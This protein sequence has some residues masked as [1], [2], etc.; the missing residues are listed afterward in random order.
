MTGT[1]SPARSRTERSLARIGRLDGQ[2]RSCLLVRPS[3][4]AEAE[5][6]DQARTAGPLAGWTLAVKDNMDVAGTVRTD[7]LGPPFRPP[8]ATDCEPVRRLRAAGAVVVA[9]ANLE[10]LSF[11]ATTQNPFWGS[12]RNPWDLSRIPGGSSGGSA[13]AVAAGLVDAALGTDTGG[14]LRNPASFCGISTLRPTH[15]LVPVTGVTPLSPS[16]DVVGPMARRVRDLGPLLAA[17]TGTAPAAGP[18]LAGLPVG[19]PAEYFTDDLSPAVAAG[20]DAILELLRSQGA[21]LRSVSFPQV[22]D[23]PD[24]M[25]VLQNSAAARS[26]REYRD[27]PRV[28]AGILE[29]IRLGARVT[30]SQQ[31]LAGRVAASWRHAVQA[32]FEQVTILI[33]PATPFTA[34]PAAGDNLVALSRRIN[35]LTGCWSLLPVPVLGLPVAAAPGGLPVGVQ[36]ISATATDWRLL[37]VGE[38]IQAVSDWHDRLPALAA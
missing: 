2:L 1:C 37:A 23:V 9:K 8:A 31:R 14:S 16:M 35:R 10:E 25:A 21:R 17:L 19:V 3:A 6:V 13:V 34:P 24:A 11:G 32:A 27:D 20:Y 28:S 29:R 7:G 26:L 5:L 33:T 36:L 12:C 38:A 30:S 15:G 22:A 18:P 4:V